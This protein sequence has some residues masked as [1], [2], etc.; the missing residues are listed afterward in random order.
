MPPATQPAPVKPVAPVRALPESPPDVP[1]QI[2][3]AQQAIAIGATDIQVL[4]ALGQPT[5]VQKDQWLYVADSP[6]GHAY[7]A[8]AFAQGHVSSVRSD[9]LP[10]WE[11]L[12]SAR[13]RIADGADASVVLME[14]GQ[15]AQR[16]EGEWWLYAPADFA[17]AQIELFI[18]DHTLSWGSAYLLAR[19]GRL[20]P[21]SAA[22]LSGQQVKDLMGAPPATQKGAQW[23]YVGIT[24]SPS[25][26]G[27]EVHTT[28]YFKAGRVAQI[29]TA[30]VPH[31]P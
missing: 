31:T 12:A 2:G 16:R 4:A 19:L 23:D 26:G 24:A 18:T 29:V 13:S 11:R 7:A 14:L 27:T 8:I 22:D 5:L 17:P 15:P 6:Q 28:V 3:M 9:W 30:A 25:G 21:G 10:G 1:H 20:K